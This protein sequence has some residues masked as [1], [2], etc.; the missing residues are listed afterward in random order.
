MRRRS[1]VPATQWGF[2]LIELVVVMIIVG[3]IAVVAIPRLVDRQIFDS[4]GFSDQIISALRYAQKQA[5][6]QR[7]NVCVAFT[8]TTLTLTIAAA[9]GAAPCDTNL[10]SPSGPSPYRITAN[11]GVAFTAIPTNFQFNALGQASSGQTMSIS[12]ASGVITVEQ[13]TGYVHP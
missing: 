3:I 9:A 12:G 2:T 4:R 5:I 1:G 11:S 8:A 6:G 7:R 10:A 13:E